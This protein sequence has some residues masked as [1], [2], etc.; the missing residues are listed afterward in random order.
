M[1][2]DEILCACYEVPRSVLRDAIDRGAELDAIQARF[3]CGRSCGSCLP[4]IRS[5]LRMRPPRR[6]GYI[7]GG[8]LAAASLA[9]LL[10]P[11]FERFVALGPANP[12]HVNLHCDEC[13]TKAPGTLRQ[14]IQANVLHRLGKRDE[15]ADF[16]HAPV[17]VALCRRCHDR[18]EDRHPVFRFREPRFEEVR[19]T[20]APH[21]CTSCHKEHDGSRVKVDR[22][23]CYNCHEEFELEDDPISVTH[24]ALAKQDRYDTCLE[25]HDFH[26]NHRYVVPVDLDHRFGADAVDAY[27]QRGRSPYGS[28]KRWPSRPGRDEAGS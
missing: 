9:A 8:A 15:P 7:A 20:L 12:G 1:Q 26:G 14:Q 11:R 4:E 28:D 23:F 24:D 22:T 3:A 21:R 18:P 16:V 10:T 5:M 27:M 2:P 6:R 19:E 25:C 13:H 17:S